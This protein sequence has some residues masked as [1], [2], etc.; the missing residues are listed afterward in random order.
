MTDARRPIRT[1]D[2]RWV[3]ALAERFVAAGITPNQVSVWSVVFAVLA[4]I[5]LAQS[6]DAAGPARI[7]LLLA[8]VA[9]I[10]LRLLC[11]LLDGL[12]AVEGGLRTKTGDIF[13]ELPDRFADIAVL[14]GAGYAAAGVTLGVELGW[15]AATL[16]V[17]V[18]Y[19]RALGAAIGAGHHFQGPMA[20]QHRMA[21]VTLGGL[22]SMVEPA[23][24]LQGGIML[25]GALV[26]V[27]LGSAVT[28]ARRTRAIAASLQARAEP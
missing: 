5:A 4:G 27:A 10:Q 1:R 25:F 17:L 8:A 16:A 6:A 23:V 3:H 19:V 28:V 14:A 26:I 11:N 22:L 24:E 9:G 21:A 7:L 13:N 20:K 2:R 15:L 12:M 18:A